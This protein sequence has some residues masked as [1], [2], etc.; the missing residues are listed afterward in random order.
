[1]PA[2]KAVFAATVERQTHSLLDLGILAPR[3]RHSHSFCIRDFAPKGARIFM[4]DTYLLRAAVL[5]ALSATSHTSTVLDEFSQN[6]SPPN[7]DVDVLTYEVFDMR[8]PLERLG[9]SELVIPRQLQQP[10]LTIVRACG[11]ALSRIDEWVDRFPNE[12]QHS[13][14][15]CKIEELNGS[16]RTCR[17]TLQLAVESVNLYVLDLFFAS[18]LSSEQAITPSSK[19]CS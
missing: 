3:A 4:M 10:I 7:A 15:L 12:H 9:D 16:L 13:N 8:T 11:D 5:Y 18:F 17:R 1:M 14:H 19:S 2:V 6:S